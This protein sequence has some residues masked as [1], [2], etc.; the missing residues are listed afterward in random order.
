[1]DDFIKEKDKTLVKEV[2]EGDFEN[3]VAMMGHLGTVRDKMNQYDNMFDPIKKKIELLKSYD[4]EVPD[5][6]FERL[7]VNTL[8]TKI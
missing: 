2:K 5:D 3:L 7:Q 1:L 8:N 4:Q 6:V